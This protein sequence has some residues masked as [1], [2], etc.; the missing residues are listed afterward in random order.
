VFAAANFA[1]DLDAAGAMRD[2]ARAAGTV[3]MLDSTLVAIP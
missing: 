2:A 3:V 1:A